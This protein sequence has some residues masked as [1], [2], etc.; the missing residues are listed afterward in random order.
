MKKV[1]DEEE[2]DKAV[3]KVANKIYDR[4]SKAGEYSHA[5]SLASAASDSLKNFYRKC[6]NV[7]DESTN[8]VV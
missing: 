4:L 2:F 6:P 3:K 1:I 5:L 8:D 7:V